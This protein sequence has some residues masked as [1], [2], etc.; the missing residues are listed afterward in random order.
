[1]ITKNNKE[2]TNKTFKELYEI[3]LHKPTPASDFVT[4]VAR[5]TQRQENTVRMW[6]AGRQQPDALAKQVIAEL[7]DADADRLFPTPM[8]E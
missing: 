4:R 6:L 5:A 2:M 3:E 1:M 8:S 7:L